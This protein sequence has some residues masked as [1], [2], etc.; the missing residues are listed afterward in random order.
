MG[1]KGTLRSVNSSLRAMERDAQR[2][3]REI[4]REEA[5]AAKYAML[6]QAAQEVAEFEE[7]LAALTSIH[8][9]RPEAVDWDALANTPKPKP[10]TPCTVNEDRA[11]A[12][13]ES[14][15]PGLLT[16]ILGRQEVQRTKLESA[17]ASARDRDIAETKTREVSFQ[18]ALN[19]WER[20]RKHAEGVVQGDPDSMIEVIRQR[21]PFSTISGLGSSVEFQSAEKGE[22]SAVVHVNGENV[23]PKES[24]SLLRS[25]KVSVKTMPKGK[26][27]E[28]YQD[29]VCGCVLR[30]GNELLALL[31]IT[32]QSAI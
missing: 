23:I 3:Q 25:G 5:A 14:F 28:L 27:Y 2:R 30:V 18:Q 19:E 4:V 20:L 31:P 8:R 21:N 16:R 26:Y 1:W 15:T 22:L 9:K 17:V 11:R 32:Q 29:Y 12:R 24:K 7:R 13:S 6:D 10:P